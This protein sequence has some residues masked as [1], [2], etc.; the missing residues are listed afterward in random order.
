MVGSSYIDKRLIS[1]RWTCVIIFIK[2]RHVLT[3]I[4][5]YKFLEDSTLSTYM[6]TTCIREGRTSISH[7]GKKI[8]ESTL[9]A[10][11]NRFTGC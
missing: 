2:W 10:T 4:H 3:L 6:H 9:V 8:L 1:L 11:V 5:T 7:L